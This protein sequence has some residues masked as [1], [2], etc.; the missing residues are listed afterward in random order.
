METNEEI[1]IRARAFASASPLGKPMA[2]ELDKA[3]LT[4]RRLADALEAATTEPEW[5]YGRDCG[6]YGVDEW[7][8]EHAARVSVQSW[9]G[10]SL[11]RRRP[12]GPWLPVEG[13]NLA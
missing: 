5:E 9:R 13:E 11:V 2:R 12:A 3:I 1:I 7:D 8:S 10:S 4:I 6:P